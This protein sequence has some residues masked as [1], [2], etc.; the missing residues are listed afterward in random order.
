MLDSYGFRANR[1]PPLGRLETASSYPLS[2]SNPGRLETAEPVIAFF[3]SDS[4]VRTGQQPIRDLFTLSLPVTTPLD[5]AIGQSEP[6]VCPGGRH[7]L[8][9]MHVSDQWEVVFTLPRDARYAVAPGEKPLLGDPSRDPARP[10][11]PVP[12]LP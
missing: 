10:E 9:N 2:S 11:A 4:P 7:E 6:S 8:I 5:F 1:G 3:F 12:L